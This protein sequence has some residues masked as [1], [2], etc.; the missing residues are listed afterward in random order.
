[1]PGVGPITAATVVGELPELGS[2]DRRRIS[3]LVGVAPMN[4]DSGLQRGKR[5]IAGGRNQI[6]RVLYMAAL[7]ARQ[8]NPAIRAFSERLTAA[9]KPYKVMMIACM[10]KLLVT[11]NAIVRSGIPW[12]PS[13]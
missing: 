13:P 5:P 12:S 9:G 3:A 6:R 2:L 4:R 10:R 11:L 1:M 8:R 7:T